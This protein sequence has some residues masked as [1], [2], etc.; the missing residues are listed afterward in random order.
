MTRNYEELFGRKPRVKL[1]FDSLEHLESELEQQY[2][3]LSEKSYALSLE[4]NSVK[5]EEV[6]NQSSKVQVRLEKV[7][8]RISS[9]RKSGTGIKVNL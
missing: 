1:D 3:N 7:R 9:M 6:R 4:P 5:T 8:N 2:A